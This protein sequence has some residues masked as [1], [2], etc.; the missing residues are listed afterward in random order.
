MPHCG[1]R[2]IYVVD[3]SSST[4]LFISTTINCVSVST[5]KTVLTY[6]GLT[7]NLCSRQ[8]VVGKQRVRVCPGGAS[9]VG[10]PSFVFGGSR[11]I[12]TGQISLP[13]FL[14][15]VCGPCPHRPVTAKYGWCNYLQVDLLTTW[16]YFSSLPTEYFSSGGRHMILA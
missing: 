2:S 6:H 14:V 12:G 15:K 7:R 16:K 3:N 13:V 5:N 4:R 8:S 9:L 1:F 11:V 10:G